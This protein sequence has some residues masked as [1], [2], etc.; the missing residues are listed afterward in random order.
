MDQPIR[1]SQTIA[2]FQPSHPCSAHVML[3][4]CQSP[5]RYGPMMNVP[6]TTSS[7]APV[8]YENQTAGRMPKTL[9]NQTAM[10]Q[11]IAMKCAGP[12]CTAP[13]K[14]DQV[15]P[16]NH[17]ATIRSPIVLP[18]MDRTTDQPIQ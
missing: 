16:G 9:S 10:M 14:S 18:K 11:P 3:E 2:V 13:S 8:T 7:P 4:E 17:F 15:E 6:S 5:L 1:N 12:R